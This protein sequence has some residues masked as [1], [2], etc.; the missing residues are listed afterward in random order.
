MRGRTVV[1][2]E[3]DEARIAGRARNVVVTVAA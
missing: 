2:H 1:S 3:L